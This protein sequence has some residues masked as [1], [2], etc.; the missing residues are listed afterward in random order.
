MFPPLI[1]GWTQRSQRSLLSSHTGGAGWPNVVLEDYVKRKLTVNAERRNFRNP[2]SAKKSVCYPKN[3]VAAHDRVAK[4]ISI[5]CTKPSKV[6]N[7]RQ[8]ELYKINI[9]LDGPERKAMLCK[10]LKDEVALLLAVEGHRSRARKEN[11]ILKKDRLLQN[12][13]KPIAFKAASTGELTTM[14]TPWITRAKELVALYRA[15]TDNTVSKAE[16]LDLLLSV[17]ITVSEFVCDLTSEI[18]TLVD[19]EVTMLTSGVRTTDHV[20][21]GIRTRISSLFLE[22]I[23]NPLFNPQIA[24][25]LPA[26]AS[27][28]GESR[29]LTNMQHCSSCH[30]HKPAD[31]FQRR[32]RAENG[33]LICRD[34]ERMKNIGQKR[35]DLGF[36]RRA[37]KALMATEKTLTKDTHPILTVLTEHDFKALF[38]TIWRKASL[39]SG[40]RD[41]YDLTFVRWNMK[42]LWT[43]WNCVLLTREEAVVHVQMPNQQNNTMVAFD[44]YNDLQGNGRRGNIAKFVSL[45]AKN[46]K[47]KAVIG[48]GGWNAGG[49][50]FS[51]M[52][53]QPSSRK[54]FIDSVVA[55]CKL[56]DFDGLLI[57][58]LVPGVG[59]RGGD[60]EDYKNFPTLL[61]EMKA[62]FKKEATGRAEDLIISITLSADIANIDY[63]DVD[64]LNQVVDIF[65]LL[66]YDFY[67]PW[68]KVTYHHAPLYNSPGNYSLDSAVQG[69]LKTAVGRQKL[70]IAVTGTARTYTIPID[71]SGDNPKK[72]GVKIL[73]DGKAGPLTISPGTLAYLEVCRMLATGVYTMIRDPVTKVSHSYSYDGDQWLSYDNDASVKEKANYTRQN[74]L[75]G[76]MVFSS[77]Q[78]DPHGYCGVPYP[79]TRAA[80]SILAPLSPTDEQAVLSDLNSRV[81]SRCLSQQPLP[82]GC[83][84]TLRCPKIFPSSFA[85]GELECPEKK[86]CT[87]VTAAIDCVVPTS[88]TLKK[89]QPFYI[90]TGSSLPATYAQIKCQTGDTAAHADSAPQKYYICYDTGLGYDGIE[91]FTCPVGSKLKGNSTVCIL[92]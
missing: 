12:V 57:D 68:S 54:T 55:F 60:P 17:T 59:N 56:Y 88:T 45:K 72:I 65:Y 41:I 78:D 53:M 9:A 69:W 23:K 51:Q 91:E 21:D 31:G 26:Q 63:Y 2:L 79:L 37:L 62:A 11:E 48:I 61:K 75:G 36:H 74:N 46:P 50:M 44:A 10:V 16:R 47:M 90:Q 71:D 8:Q 20:L 32:S 4:P 1:S 13:S 83:E 85:P 86:N 25:F 84:T 92:D 6:Q 38:D 81:E 5:W 7:W 22:F 3:S 18:S 43:P 82:G 87:F 19:R 30:A 27:A 52:A 70:S 40:R 33:A 89:D 66:T 58:W 76:I 15:L 14:E 49:F 28:S 73:S 77:D 29:L 39:V 34:C 35:E 80:R 64:A 67:G 42:E 24:R